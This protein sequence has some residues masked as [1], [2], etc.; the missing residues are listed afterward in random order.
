MRRGRIFI[1]IGLIL[2]LGLVAAVLLLQGVFT[3][4]GPDTDGTLIQITP[5]PANTV[6]VVVLTQQVFRGQ[7]I[8]EGMVELA[9]IPEEQYDETEMFTSLEEVLGRISRFDLPANLPLTE[10]MLAFSPDDLTLTGSDA[11]LLIP[12]GMVA[13]SIPVDRLTSVSYGLRR[14]DTVNVIVTVL[15]VDLDTNFQTVLPN[16]SSAVI[17]PGPAVVLTVDPAA[18][19]GRPPTE[20]D[21]IEVGLA[22]DELLQTL[23]AQIVTGGLISPVGRLELDPTLGQPFYVVPSE[24]QRPRSVSQTLI[25][26]A[27]VLQLGTFPLEGAQLLLEQQQQAQ[28]GQEPPPDEQAQDAAVLESQV[29]E[30]PDIITLVVSPQDAVTL[31]FLLH[32]GSRLSLAMRANEDDTQVQTEAVTLQFLLDQYNIQVPAK[33]PFGLEPRMNSLDPPVLQNDI[34]PEQPQQ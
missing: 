21:Q 26:G 17:A 30:T 20:G 23:T 2:I 10:S 34:I 32:T 19:E 11:S 29:T 7:E 6:T 13:V 27:M 31:N 25:Q 3:G 28:D 16:S 24:S 33:R 8:T 12:R 9:A 5:E 18:A 4:G 1:Y 22:V 14:G 15:F